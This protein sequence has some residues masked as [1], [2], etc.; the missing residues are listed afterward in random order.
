MNRASKLLF[1]LLAAAPAAGDQHEP[2]SQARGVAAGSSMTAV[3]TVEAINQETR[4]VTLRK[5]DGELVQMVIGPEARNLAQ[6]E[7]GDRVTVT[8]DIGLLVAVGPAGQA[9]ARTQNTEIARTP[10]GAR[11]GGSIRETTAVTATVVAI[12]AAT[13]IVTLRGPRQT[14]ELEVAPD[15]DLSKVK[16]G[17]QVGA[18]YTESFALRVR[19][20]SVR[21]G[22]IR[23]A[24]R[25]RAVRDRETP[26]SRDRAR[27]PRRA[28][29]T[30]PSPR[31]ASTGT[32]PRRRHA[33]APPSRRRRRR[34]SE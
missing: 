18:V 34:C 23:N 7:K 25:S 6:V 19:S 9:P 31:M 33:R 26:S 28:L 17:D 3:A 24:A 21:R 30:A 13:R 8:Y 12:D 27:S 11:P 10:A 22:E 16:V 1:V 14:V 29:R 4:E 2:E 15:I 5:E 32:G 20:R